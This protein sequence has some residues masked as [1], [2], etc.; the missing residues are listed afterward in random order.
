MT[1]F[2]RLMIG[3]IVLPLAIGAAAPCTAQTTAAESIGTDPG[4]DAAPANS[5][6]IRLTPEQR[7]AALEE[8]AARAAAGLQP[9]GAADRRIHGEMG[10]EVGTSG[11]RAAYGMAVV[12][13][14][15]NGAAAVAFE[16]DRVK[17]RRH[18]R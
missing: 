3:S 7:E 13:L 14:G 16:T 15:E 10:I 6:S 2:I 18:R 8:G 5:D 1:R 9:D 11:E 17:Y 4:W 12:P